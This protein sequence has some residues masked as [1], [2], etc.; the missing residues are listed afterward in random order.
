ME[1]NDLCHAIRRDM[2]EGKGTIGEVL[3]D[4]AVKAKILQDGKLLNFVENDILPRLDAEAEK[5]NFSLTL[6]SWA[7]GHD[8]VILKKV[9]K[10]AE[11]FTAAL[12]AQDVAMTVMTRTVHVTRFTVNFSWV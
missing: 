7:T 5:G 10:N 9:I 6:D 1:H 2:T 11:F 12:R 3:R 4:K 8:E